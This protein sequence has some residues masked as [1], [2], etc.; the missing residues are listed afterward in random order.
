MP[1]CMACALV[2]AALAHTHFYAPLARFTIYSHF[3]CISNEWTTWALPSELFENSL[4]SS[5]YANSKWFRSTSPRHFLSLQIYRS[6]VTNIFDLKKR[7]LDTNITLP[8]YLPCFSISENHSGTKRNPIENQNSWHAFFPFTKYL[9]STLLQ[10]T[11]SDSPI[12]TINRCTWNVLLMNFD[13]PIAFIDSILWNRFQ[14][15][16]GTFVR[17]FGQFFISWKLVKWTGNAES[18]SI[19]LKNYL[20]S[21]NGSIE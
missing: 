2:F 14:F 21:F 6:E 10:Q 9:M 5:V 7:R 15:H 3:H 13:D 18:F 20:W 8:H 4:Q 19:S 1:M 16:C 17:F 11:N 12:Q